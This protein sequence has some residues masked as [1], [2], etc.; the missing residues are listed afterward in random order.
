MQKGRYKWG[1]SSREKLEI[2]DPGMHL[3]VDLTLRAG[4][5][6]LTVA[7]TF[8]D[9]AAQNQAFR[10]EHSEKMWPDSIH[11]VLNDQ[12]C[13]EAIDVYPYVNG[14]T[15][16]NRNQC[17]VM[18]GGIMLCGALIGVEMTSGINWDRDGEW[19]TDHKLKDYGHFQKAN[20]GQA[21]DLTRKTAIQAMKRQSLVH[22]YLLDMIDE[23]KGSQDP[24]FFSKVREEMVALCDRNRA[25][26]GGLAR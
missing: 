14:A 8:R 11:N 13:V 6:D 15:S 24:L 2:L 3:A 12:G 21:A 7:Y 10:S 9:K 25:F 26:F 18:V 16:Y 23:G 20:G 19:V 22:E 1:K 5:M 17:G 4:L